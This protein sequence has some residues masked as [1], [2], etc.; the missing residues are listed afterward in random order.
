MVSLTGTGQIGG[1]HDYSGAGQMDG[2]YDYDELDEIAQAEQEE[3]E[4]AMRES[5]RMQ[6]QMNE[7]YTRREENLQS[8]PGIL[9]YQSNWKQN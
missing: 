5:L 7:P 6:P 1:I 3:L 4:I 8:A 9:F 2:I